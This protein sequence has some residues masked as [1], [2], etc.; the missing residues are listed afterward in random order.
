MKTQAAKARTAAATVRDRGNENKA[1][2]L[3]AYADH[4]DS[5]QVVDRT[6]DVSSLLG[7]IL[8]SH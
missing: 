5:G 1:Q 2:R 6:D 4:L 3:E 8:H 7:R